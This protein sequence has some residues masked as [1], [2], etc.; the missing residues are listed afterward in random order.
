MSIRNSMT[1]VSAAPASILELA[2]LARGAAPDQADPAAFLAALVRQF[3][4][5]KD[6]GGE[7]P[8]A[9]AEEGAPPED[10]FQTLLHYSS[11]LDAL[12]GTEAPNGNGLPE[13]DAS[14]P[15]TAL[16]S[17][18]DSESEKLAT[19]PELAALAAYLVPPPL[20]PSESP[21][22]S[23]EET[24]MPQMSAGNASAFLLRQTPGQDMTGAPGDV[25]VARG[26]RMTFPPDAESAPSGAISSAVDDSD[27]ALPHELAA[28]PVGKDSIER[29]AGEE[30]IGPFDEKLA[31]AA[32]AGF[33]V[34][35]APSAPVP[36][37]S[38]MAVHE[39]V[40]DLNRPLNQPEWQDGLGD[41][42]IW[43]ADKSVQA[44]E[45]RLN[46]AHLGPLGIRI[47][48]DQDQAAIHFSAHHAAV[49]EAIE[50]AI[51]RLREMLGAQ[52]IT[53][54]DIHVTAPPGMSNESGAS[55]DFSRQSRFDDRSQPFSNRASEKAE[56]AL[57]DSGRSAAANGLLN[58]YV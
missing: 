16:P 19:D 45:I 2:Q 24:P 7:I 54:V 28:D 9:S 51:P 48:M 50:A 56:S 4:S 47:Q 12:S 35:A 29:G 58:V 5:M 20:A 36:P 10:A 38:A 49:R 14:L 55:P 1:A 52:Q 46:P 18:D 33:A 30:R 31:V 53:L 22:T 13:E 15:E 25:G 17:R 23:G 37:G 8:A 40:P 41:R 42:I 34:P 43:M 6:A 26:E 39:S 32:N 21:A 11:S 27:M 44:A 3:E 57:T